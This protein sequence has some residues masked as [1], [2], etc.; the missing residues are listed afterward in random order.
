[1]HAHKVSKNASVEQIFEQ[2]D[3]QREECNDDEADPVHDPKQTSGS[4]RVPVVE[5]FGNQPHRPKLVTSSAT[6][7]ATVDQAFAVA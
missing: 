7:K 2:N 1:M 3:T 5:S 6:V 4:T